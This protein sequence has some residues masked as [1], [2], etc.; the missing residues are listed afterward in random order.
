MRLVHNVFPT[1]QK[2]ASL[3]AAPPAQELPLSTGPLQNRSG[4][5]PARLAGRP[6][7]SLVPLLP[8]CSERMQPPAP[9]PQALACRRGKGHRTEEQ[10]SPLSWAL[11]GSRHLNYTVTVPQ[12]DRQTQTDNRQA[13]RKDTT[14]SRAPAG[15]FCAEESFPY[16]LRTGA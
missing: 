14:D 10:L 7:A 5:T 3:A 15:C 4:A 1:R 11:T 16:W 8:H 6:S 2:A 13:L 12:T 9:G